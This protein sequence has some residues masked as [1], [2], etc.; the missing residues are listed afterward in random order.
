MATC[1]L[2]R[3]VRNPQIAAAALLEGSESSTPFASEYFA[4]ARLLRHLIT[5][6]IESLAEISPALETEVLAF[7]SL[8]PTDEGRSGVPS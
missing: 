3:V 7:D 6:M 1:D 2:A 5:G 8:R 4:T